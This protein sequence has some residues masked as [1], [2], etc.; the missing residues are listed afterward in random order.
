MKTILQN[1]TNLN[2]KKENTGY[3][4]IADDDRPDY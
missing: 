3:Q 2:L 1:E 4:A